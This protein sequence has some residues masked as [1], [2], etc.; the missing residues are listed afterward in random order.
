[1]LT[2][3]EVI[4]LRKLLQGKNILITGGT[5]S[6]GSEIFRQVLLYDPK[7]VRVY[8]RDEHKQFEMQ[9]EFA[10]RPNIRFLIGD[11]RDK[12]RLQRA[13]E[14]IDIVFHAAALKHVPYCEYNP[15]EAVKT[16]VLGT[17]NVIEAAL[18]E[19]VE[20]VVA[21]STDKVVNP[22]NTLGAT[23]LMAEKLV[24]SANHYKGKR[25]TVFSC[26]RF[27]NVMG[28]RGSV[29]PLFRKQISEGGPV[30]ITDPNM[31]R[32]MMSIA[33]AVNLV[34]K[35]AQVSRGGETFILKMPT[36]RL[37]DLVEVLI[38][39]LAPKYG[40]LP[41]NIP[42]KYIGARPGEKMHED[43]LSP[44]EIPRT[45]ESKDMFI[46]SDRVQPS[47]YPFLVEQAGVTI[48]SSRDGRHLTKRKIKDLLY[49]ANLLWS[50][51]SDLRSDYCAEIAA[52][53]EE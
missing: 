15:F 47:A 1:M 22:G 31:T 12:E 24:A 29:I 45:F 23:K 17:Q 52:G 32:F 42:V 53:L 36:L 43:L 6:I 10:G 35:A 33:D 44:D 5:G 2:T 37:I 25:K 49:K 21:I 16:N 7:V 28:S 41:K 48:Y 19:E 8:S 40:Y 34:L 3:D 4:P 39:E 51:E 46:V 20:K 9:Q 30:T 50:R 11:V 27:G 14:E 18:D 26:V 13:I 38:K